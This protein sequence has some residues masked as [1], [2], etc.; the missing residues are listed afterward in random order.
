MLTRLDGDEQVTTKEVR[1]AVG[2]AHA[3]EL[4]ARMDQAS[5]QRSEAREA[6]IELRDYIKQVRVA[7]LLSGRS[8][9]AKG[10]AQAKKLMERAEQRYERAIERLDE[11]LSDDPKLARHLDRDFDLHKGGGA[12]V[13]PDVEGVPRIKY[14]ARAYGEHVHKEIP[15]RVELLRAALQSA[16]A[17]P[18]TT[19]PTASVLSQQQRDERS[20]LIKAKLKALPSV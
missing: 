13:A 10:G 17:N 4:R 14:H 15:S 6:S 5:W 1:Q 18:I 7:D 16:I 12:K 19:A 8:D 11:L 2:A 9:N 20:A 3:D